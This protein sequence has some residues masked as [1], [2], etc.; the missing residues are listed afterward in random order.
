MET[1]F[2]CNYCF[3]LM[4]IWNM[5]GCY[6][7]LSSSPGFSIAFHIL[8]P[9]AFL[10]PP[11]E[12]ENVSAWET[13]ADL[14][15]QLFS[16]VK[17]FFTLFVVWFFWPWSVGLRN[18]EWQNINLCHVLYDILLYLNLFNTIQIFLIEGLINN[19]DNHLNDQN[20]VII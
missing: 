16:L 1:F 9:V 14:Q 6:F 10:F 13:A 4:H 2:A 15:V 8:F 17:V 18:D 3:S 7:S 5:V 12:P 20:K 19:L 11:I